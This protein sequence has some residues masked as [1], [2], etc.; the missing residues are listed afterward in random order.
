MQRGDWYKSFTASESPMKVAETYY[1]IVEV[2]DDDTLLVDEYTYYLNLKK[3]IKTSK[4]PV[5]RTSKWWLE[6][7]IQNNIYPI[8]REKVPFI[9]HM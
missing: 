1:R 5:Q 3:Y 7:N 6:Q 2:I 8:E 4:T 9:L